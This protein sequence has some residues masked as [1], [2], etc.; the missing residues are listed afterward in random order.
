M[1][2]FAFV[3]GIGLL[4]LGIAKAQI[5]TIKI[6]NDSL[7]IWIT[8]QPV[9]NATVQVTRAYR[10]RLLADPYRPAYHFC[11]PEDKGAPGDPNGAFFYNGQI[12]F[13]VFVRTIWK[14]ILMGSC[15]QQRYA[16][17]EAPPGCITT[18]RW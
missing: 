18:R 1:K 17:L 8:D 6:A 14:R 4:S 13:D 10:E 3:L 12:P 15:I 11:I 2:F 5:D 16:A 7:N 9:P